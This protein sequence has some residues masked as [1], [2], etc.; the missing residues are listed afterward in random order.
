MKSSQNVS[1]SKAGEI[2]EPAPQIQDDRPGPQTDRPVAIVRALQKSYAGKP[3]VDRVSFDIRKGE[4]CGLLGP[5]GAGK[6]TILRM[7][8]GNS[9]PDSGSLEVLGYPVPREARRMRARVGIV[10]QSDNLDP[11]LSVIENLFVYGRYFGI[12][13]N[14]LEMRVHELLTFASLTDWAGSRIN[15]LSGGMMRRLSIARAL[16]NNP[17]LL[18][19]DEP[20]TGLDPQARHTIWQQLRRMQRE[21]MTLI[22]TTHY[23]EEAERLCD[24]II[25]IDNGA[26]L[27]D[28]SPEQLISE[29]IEAHVLEVHGSGVSEWCGT[30][31]LPTG[32]RCEK[33]GETVFFYGENL[34]WI[35]DRLD[36][37]S[38]LRYSYR[39]ANLE[40]VFLKL[41]GRDLRDV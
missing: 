38:R 37:E 4:F 40:D 32:V 2:P 1:V 27:A 18:I 12:A 31:E 24:R 11:D 35:V 8:V 23:M 28:R 26:L 13:G 41:T 10:P 33:V 9:M 30:V 22:L 3:V 7:L 20:T 25:L 17:E 29:E 14:V 36:G 34:H 5:N 16:I 15:Q 6:T 19:L 39:P 21:G